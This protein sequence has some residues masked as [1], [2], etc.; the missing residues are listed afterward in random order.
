MLLSRNARIPLRMVL[1]TLKTSKAVLN[2][3]AQGIIIGVRISDSLKGGLVGGSAPHTPGPMWA[4]G[5]N[6]TAGNR[7]CLLGGT[8]RAY[9]GKPPVPTGGNRPACRGNRPGCT[10]NRPSAGRLD[11]G[12][13]LGLLRQ[14]SQ[15]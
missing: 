6:G 2:P 5:R 1:D 3:P 14:V 13:Y 12:D 10:G 7:P 8:A 9:W 15:S 4:C 11:T